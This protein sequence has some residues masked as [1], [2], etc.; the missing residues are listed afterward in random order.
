[1]TNISLQA[2]LAALEQEQSLKGYQLAELEPKVEALIAMQ[3]NKLG[4]LIQ[5]QQIY[6]E[7]EDIQDDA[8][9]DDYDWKIIPPP[10]VD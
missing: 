9:I 10:P 6:Y 2:A 4:L 8:E 3:L 5:E 7:E 1:M